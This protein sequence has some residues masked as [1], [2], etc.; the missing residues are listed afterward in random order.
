[1]F[2][3]SFLLSKSSIGIDTC[4]VP[5]HCL[6]KIHL[7][8]LMPCKIGTTSLEQENLCQVKHTVFLSL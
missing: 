2:P 7:K 8:R 3:P 5:L 4:P 1:M 6:F